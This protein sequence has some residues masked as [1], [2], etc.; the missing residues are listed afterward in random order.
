MSQFSSLWRALAVL[1]LLFG[2]AAGSQAQDAGWQRYEDFDYGFRIDLP[3]GLFELRENEAERMT[4]FEVGGLG[5]IDIYGA[6]N[7]EGLTPQEFMDVL[8]Q[9][10]R[11]AEVTYRTGG[12]SWFVLSGYYRRERHEAEELIFYAKF[13]F[14]P[15]RSRLSAFEISYPLRDKRRFDPIVT[16]LEKSLRA[17]R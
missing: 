12:R 13:M 10:D 8:E 7:P 11:I 1:A 9:A 6:E 5:Q 15:D 16:R 4:F 2:F 14:S 17:P 3:L